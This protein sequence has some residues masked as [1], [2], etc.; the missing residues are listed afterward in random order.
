MC[1]QLAYIYVQHD[2]VALFPLI[3]LEVEHC[4]QDS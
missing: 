3:W 4:K 2:M 1:V